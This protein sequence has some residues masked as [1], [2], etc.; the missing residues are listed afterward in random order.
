MTVHP[1]DYRPNYVTSA[2]ACDLLAEVDAR[3]WISLGSGGRRVQHYGYRY[4][5]RTRTVTPD[6]FVGALPP[7]LAELARR[8]HRET[9]FAAVP[10]QV[11]VNEYHPGQ[12][13]SAH[14]DCVPCFGPTIA[15]ISLGAARDM[16]VHRRQP[17]Q[18]ALTLILEPRSLLV[19]HDETR[20]QWYHGI[21][22]R[23]FD[24]A[25]ILGRRVSLTF[26]TV[27]LDPT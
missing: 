12:G 25:G 11:I 27:R 13:I 22:A 26:R 10:D 8:L 19:L 17:P 4:S 23:D 7:F 14:I 15:T 20:Y 6:D 24:D 16:Q 3:S 21:E 18:R 2:T 5:Y 1:F 9:P